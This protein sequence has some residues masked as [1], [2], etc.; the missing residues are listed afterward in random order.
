MGTGGGNGITA[1]YNKN[2]KSV[3]S[4]RKQIADFFLMGKN[5]ENDRCTNFD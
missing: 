4:P 2:K 3:I 5:Y 1:A